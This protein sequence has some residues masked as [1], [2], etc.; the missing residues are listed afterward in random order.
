MSLKNKVAIVTGANSGIGLA[1]AVE[2]ARQGANIVID[3]VSHPEAAD[4]L[5]KQIIALG[6]QAI[7]IK[8]DVSNVV[9]KADEGA[10]VVGVRSASAARRTATMLRQQFGSRC[11]ATVAPRTG[12]VPPSPRQPMPGCR[13]RQRHLQKR[14]MSPNHCLRG[15]H[16]D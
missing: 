7:T 13:W 5:E 12:S 9:H 10:V 3:F 4:V 16:N 14:G 6:D 2:L 8:A 1:V 11:P 15:K